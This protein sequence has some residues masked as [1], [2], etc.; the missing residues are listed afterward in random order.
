M[1]FI[2]RLLNA[3]EQKNG[4]HKCRDGHSGACMNVG[5]PAPVPQTD[6]LCGRGFG[7]SCCR[8]GETSS[9]RA[10]CK[11]S[12]SVQYLRPCCQMNTHHHEFGQLAIFSRI[13]TKWFYGSIFPI[14]LRMFV[15]YSLPVSPVPCKQFNSMTWPGTA[16]FEPLLPPPALVQWNNQ[17]FCLFCFHA[18]YWVLRTHPAF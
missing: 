16:V 14:F 18:C 6:S 9:A 1:H 7:G 8:I 15:T 12:L 2:G 4:T 5:F 13:S 10:G 17:Y 3:V 11:Q